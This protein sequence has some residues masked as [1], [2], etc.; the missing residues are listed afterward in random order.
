VTC[1][2]NNGTRIFRDDTDRSSYL[3]LLSDMLGRFPLR[4]HHYV[5]MDH[6]VHLVLSDADGALSGAMKR[7][8]H[9]Y[10]Y[11]VKRKYAFVGQLWQGR[12]S[13]EPIADDTDL[14]TCGVSVEMSPVLAH[15]VK[16]PLD[17]PWSSFSFY[18]EGSENALLS[19]SS[20]YLGLAK[21]DGDRRRIYRLLVH[22]WCTKK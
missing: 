22:Q 11:Y 2:G 16:D 8:N 13:A 15:L 12:F 10:T 17:H 14:L 21:N 20:A 3:A 1:R 9:A 4:L 18:T 19:P 5:L 7:L 6:L